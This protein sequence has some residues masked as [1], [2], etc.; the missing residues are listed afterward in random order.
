[1]KRSGENHPET[2]A[3]DVGDSVALNVNANERL[4]LWS[5]LTKQREWKMCYL[6]VQAVTHQGDPDLTNRM[7]WEIC[8]GKLKKRVN[9]WGNLEQQQFMH[10][11]MIIRWNNRPNRT[12]M[13]ELF[14][15]TCSIGEGV[16]LSAYRVL[17]CSFICQCCSNF[18]ESLLWRS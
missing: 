16:V 1:M 6:V 14:R 15:L 12:D 2:T 13:I 11:C 10:E 8:R 7:S 3:H 4:I 5:R 9:I 17:S 18:W